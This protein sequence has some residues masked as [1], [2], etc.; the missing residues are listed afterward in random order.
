[1]T[2]KVKTSSYRMM[3]IQ[4][5]RRRREREARRARGSNTTNWPTRSRNGTPVVVK[6]ASELSEADRTRYPALERG[7]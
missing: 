2:Q 4:R 5:A 3:L 1:M 6:H 7:R